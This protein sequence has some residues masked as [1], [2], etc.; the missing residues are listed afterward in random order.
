MSKAGGLRG[1]LVALVGVL[2]LTDTPSAC[3]QPLAN[4]A[5]LPAS[6][7]VLRG[8]TIDIDVL[9]ANAR[10]VEIPFPLPQS[11]A[12]TLSVQAQSWRVILRR[13]SQAAIESLIPAGSFLS[14]RYHLTLP[15]DAEGR[16]ILAIVNSDVGELRTVID[17]VEKGTGP[18]AGGFGASDGEFQHQ[19]IL[20][21]RLSIN[22]P[23]Y[24]ITGIGNP[25][26]KFQVSFKYRLF[27]FGEEP[28]DTQPP[29]SIQV[30]YTQRSFWEYGP[31]YDT[32][33]MPELMYQWLLRPDPESP[34]GQ[35][36]FLGLQAGWLHESNG[37]SGSTERSANM[38]YVRPLFSVG[39]PDDWHVLF[40]PQF[41]FY[42]LGLE[43]NPQLY[44]YRGNSSL[45]TTLAKGNGV[46]LSLTLL[47]G[48]HFEHGSRELDLSIPVHIPFFDFSTYVM[49]QYFDGY[50]EA[51]IDYQQHTS[52]LRAGIEF[53]R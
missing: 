34:P 4:V 48:E 26:A 13:D 41:W 33:Y 25:P 19:R 20:G 51:L 18:A 49:V 38:A 45:T 14:V 8:S 30:G 35:G 28:G 21:G 17:I 3:A 11:V 1:G 52:Q 12:A 31:F 32:S 15:P 5:L 6:D 43:A 44:Q 22:Q 7:T 46:S 27:G 39:S 37:R 40:A 47:P 2:L 24:F 16:A 36:S 29:H 10:E 9:A 23:I 50:A 42:F 53:V